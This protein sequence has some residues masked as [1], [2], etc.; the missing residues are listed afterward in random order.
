LFYTFSANYWEDFFM[1]TA[2]VLGNGISRQQLDLQM[3]SACGRIYGC[4]ALYRTFAPAV[5]VSTDT[6]ISEAIQHSGYS[7]TNVHYTRKPLAGLGAR[8]V[9][10]EYFGYSSGPI[11]AA[12]AAQDGNRTIY[13][14]GFDMG[15]DQLGMFNN[16]YADTEFYKKSSSCATYNGNWIR[17]LS[18]IIEQFSD[19]T[20]VRVYG[21]TTA[22]IKQ[23]DSLKNLQHLPIEV[24]I[25]RI[26]NTKDF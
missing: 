7:Q 8:R 24:F 4:N 26:N 6:P 23:F 5:L 14:V 11:A 9:P 17:Q 21:A 13:L 20:F 18:T 22:E 19:R 10:Q 15:P 3:L 2:F 25:D 12:I 1:T 16:V